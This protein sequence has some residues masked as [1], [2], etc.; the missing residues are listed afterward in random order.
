MQ[1]VEE[2]VFLFFKKVLFCIKVAWVQI[3]TKGREK[4][5]SSSATDIITFKNFNFII[6]HTI[7]IMAT[8]T[9]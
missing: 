7:A 2:F 8:I 5:C 4:K 1:R 9:S 3:I 6:L